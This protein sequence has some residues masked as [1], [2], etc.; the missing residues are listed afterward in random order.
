MI[1]LDDSFVIIL[2]DHGLRGGRVTHTKL[3]SLEVNNPM[4]SISVPKKLRKS[5]NIL[6]ILRENS[7][8]LQTHY[9]I[10]ATLLDILKYQPSSNFTDRSYVAFNGEY[11]TSLLRTQPDEERTCKNLPIPISYC[12]C[13]FPLEDVKSGRTS[14]SWPVSHGLGSA[15]LMRLRHSLRSNTSSVLSF[16]NSISSSML[17]SHRVLGLPLVRDRTSVAEPP[18][19]L[20]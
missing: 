2:G 16:S 10:R 3:G 9:D 12:T 17:S 19:S 5:T 13:Q 15:F 14:S 8:R 20:P 7:V 6:S 4:F 11:G 18:A 1:Q